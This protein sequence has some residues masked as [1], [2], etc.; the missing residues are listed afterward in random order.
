MN[1]EQ[2]LCLALSQVI[3]MKYRRYWTHDLDYVL[4]S[5]MERLSIVRSLKGGTL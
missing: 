1:I 3:N 5:V 2:Q 4:F